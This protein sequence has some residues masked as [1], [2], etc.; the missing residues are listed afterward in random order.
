MCPPRRSPRRRERS[1]LTRVR[2]A[3]RPRV[4]RRSVSGDTS[5]VNVRSRRPVTVRQAQF[6]AMLSP[7]ARAARRCRVLMVRR[8]PAPGDERRS[9]LPVVWMMPVN[10]AASRFELRTEEESPEPGVA[11]ALGD[12]LKL[13][14]IDPHTVAFGAL[15]DAHA[16]VLDRDELLAALRAAHE[17]QTAD[18]L[19]VGAEVL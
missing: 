13:A 15:L 10:N 14:G 12:H 11:L 3:A 7:S 1:R 2:G 18:L 8:A 17:R 6:T 19:L 16:V 4:V 9:I 5:T